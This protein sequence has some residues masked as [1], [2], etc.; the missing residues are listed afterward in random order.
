MQISGRFGAKGMSADQG[1]GIAQGNPK[2]C[3][4]D[5]F[6]WRVDGRSTASRRTAYGIDEIADPA[7]ECVDTGCIR[8]RRRDEAEAAKFG[9]AVLR[10]QQ[11]A[12]AG[13]VVCTVMALPSL[14][15]EGGVG[16]LRPP[17]DAVVVSLVSP[18][19][20]IDPDQ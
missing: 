19:R 9:S 7:C 1:I 15:A 16:A 12:A 11:R 20:R 6:D 10:A 18:S 8:K 3:A 2:P 4:V 13:E 17:R 14:V 5:V